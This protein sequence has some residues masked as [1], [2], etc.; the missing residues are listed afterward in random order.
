MVVPAHSSRIP[1]SFDAAHEVIKYIISLEIST[2]AQTAN[3]L[4]CLIGFFQFA[5]G[6]HLGWRLLRIGFLATDW[7]SDNFSPLVAPVLL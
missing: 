4:P 1:I 6:R 7:R 3:K 5:D 2:A